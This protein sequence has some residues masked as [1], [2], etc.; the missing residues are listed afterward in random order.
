M[1]AIMRRSTAASLYNSQCT[2]LVFLFFFFTRKNSVVK[3]YQNAK[4]G[5]LQN[6]IQ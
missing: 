4:P 6:V 3:P 1:V 5:Y 2:F